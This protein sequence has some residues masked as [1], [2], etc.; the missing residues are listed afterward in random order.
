[1]LKNNKL[2]LNLI[3][4][5]LFTIIYI[6]NK[7]NFNKKQLSNNDIIY[8]SLVTHTTVGYGDIYP[9]TTLGK[10]ITSLH[11]LFVFIVNLLV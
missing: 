6:K 9:T 4:Y 5:L 11:I 7:N 2:F 1:M 10:Y 8:Y 3:I